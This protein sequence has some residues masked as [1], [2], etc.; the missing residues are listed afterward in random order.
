MEQFTPIPSVVPQV[1]VSEYDV[2]L[3]PVI[4]M[5]EMS[6]IAVPAFVNV[7]AG[8]TF[9]DPTVVVANVNV[10][11]DS[12]AVEPAATPVPVSETGCGDP[13]ALSATSSEADSAPTV[14][15][16]NVTVIA[17]LAPAAKL[18]PHVLV[19]V[20]SVGFA[21]PML[22]PLPV[23]LSVSADFPVF[24]SVM[25]CVAA[26][27]PSVVVGKVRLAGERLTTG[28]LVDVG[29]KFTTF[30]TFSEPSPVAAS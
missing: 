7:M 23:P 1:C 26:A 14:N 19:C 10:F 5:L 8:A 11:A 15:G 17:Q 13:N 25:V 3:V 16:L 30:A 27:T 20:K 4:P 2:A 24:F 18:V 6:R 28:E 12:T 22:I 21:P 29:H 9:V